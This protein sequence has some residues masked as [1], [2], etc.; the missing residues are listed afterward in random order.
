M[1][2]ICLKKYSIKLLFKFK[3]KKMKNKPEII[4]LIIDKYII[5]VYRKN[6]EEQIRNENINPVSK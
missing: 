4:L 1:L 2:K 5:K 6:S 3:K